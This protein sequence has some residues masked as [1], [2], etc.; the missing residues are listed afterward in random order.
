MS[1]QHLISPYRIITESIIK[2]RRIM[3]D[4]HLISPYR[5][6]N[7]SIIKITRIMEMTNK[8]GSLWLLSKISLSAPK[9]IYRKQYGEYTYWS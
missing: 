3:S 8:Y 1:D 5:I 9:E 4:Q 2:I 6:I 7:E